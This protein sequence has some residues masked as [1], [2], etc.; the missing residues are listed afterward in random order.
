LS[1]HCPSTKGSFYFP[2]HIKTNQVDFG[3]QVNLGP[4]SL[5]F[6][7]GFGTFLSTLGLGV[8][9]STLTLGVGF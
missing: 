7:F 6:A 2:A 5:A 8:F 3:T 9:K 1:I 4:A